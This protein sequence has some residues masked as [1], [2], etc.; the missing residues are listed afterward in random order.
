MVRKIFSVI[1]TFLIM[2]L[3]A[4]LSTTLI[5]RSYLSFDTISKVIEEAM[6][7]GS[8]TFD[9]ALSEVFKQNG[10]EGKISDYVDTKELEN[11][12]KDYASKLIAY[13]LGDGQMPTINNEEINDLLDKAIE[14]YE[15]KTGKKI[16]RTEV[17]NALNEIDKNVEKSDTLSK[18]LDNNNLGVVKTVYSLIASKT[19][20][21]LLA[22]ILVF[23]IGVLFLLNMDVVKTLTYLISAFLIN[24][25]CIIII[26]LILN[27]IFGN[28]E[29]VKIITNPF[30]KY[31]LISLG[32]SLIFVI[33]TVIFK[34]ISKRNQNI[35]STIN[36]PTQ[37]ITESDIREDNEKPVQ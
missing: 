6:P 11:L 32:I 37:Q 16:D 18:Q 1:T 21:I 23:L 2:L 12:I 22:V 26:P 9:N 24:G 17:D 34:T 28:I 29:I 35:E 27:G 13:E 15:K 3:L 25:V 8:K 5:I 14:Q 20:V 31:G 7:E 4:V 19:L 30:Y 33:L 36:Y 10:Y